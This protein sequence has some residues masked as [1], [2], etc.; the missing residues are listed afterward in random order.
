MTKQDKS[1]AA[2][3][4][5]IDALSDPFHGFSGNH[6]REGHLI[7]WFDYQGFARAVIAHDRQQHKGIDYEALY[8]QMCERCDSLDKELAK[9]EQQHRGEPEYY[10][11]GNEVF[12]KTSPEMSDFIRSEG[13]PLYLNPRAAQ[14]GEAV[15]YLR[16]DHLQKIRRSGPMHG[17]I[18]TQPRSD[19]VA[20]YTEQPAAPCVA[21]MSDKPTCGAQNAECEVQTTLEGALL[22][23]KE[24]VNFI[25]ARMRRLCEKFG[26]QIPGFDNESVVAGAGSLIGGILSK[27]D[28]TPTVKESLT[29]TERTVTSDQSKGG[30]YVGLVKGELSDD[31]ILQ[32]AVE[33]GL[34]YID[35]DGHALSG[36]HGDTKNGEDIL[37]FARALL[38]RHTRL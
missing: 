28:A 10:A 5:E 1:R 16:K 30:D 29:V 33:A 34:C 25:A 38:T 32:L 17:E 4:A 31:E 9:Y 18:G 19:M 12:H 21:P 6:T 14:R 13:Q 23:D 36:I 7:P 22:L 20:V 15:A 35:R 2:F 37:D 8:E 24:A 3:E 26:Y 11:L 27:M